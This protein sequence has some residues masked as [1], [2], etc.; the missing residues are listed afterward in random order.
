MNR[1]QAAARLYSVAPGQF[2]AERAAIAAQLK[3]AGDVEQAKEV[4]AL[5]K[6]TL[7]AHVVNRFLASH[8]SAVTDIVDLGERLR[9]AQADLDADEIRSLS[10]QRSSLVESIAGR[11]ISAAREDDLAPGA[12]VQDEVRQSILA[13]VMDPVAAEAVCSGMLIRAI[14]YAGFGTVDLEDATAGPPV[15]LRVIAGGRSA[16]G[17]GAAGRRPSRS[18]PGQSTDPEPEASTTDEAAPK[19]DA[20][21]KD[22][23]AKDAAARRASRRAQLATDAKAAADTL[24]R[25]EQESAHACAGQEKAAEA[26]TQIKADLERAESELADAQAQAR[27]RRAALRHAESDTRRAARRLADAGS[28]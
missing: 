8:S 12:S 16:D 17:A 5:R 24:A 11:A 15:R 13:A 18:S 25:A 2:V 28:D 14:S 23:A 9:T 21:A 1:Q 10:G 4:R 3:A 7:A 26:V 6:P 27:A 19:R 20:S 22:A